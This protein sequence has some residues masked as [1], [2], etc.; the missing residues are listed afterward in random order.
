MHFAESGRGAGLIKV[1]D[2]L[3]R[4]AAEEYARKYFLAGRWRI[5]E[6]AQ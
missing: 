3:L 2:F 6:V 5:V 4:E 1:G